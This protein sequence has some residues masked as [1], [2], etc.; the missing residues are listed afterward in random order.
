MIYRKLYLKCDTC[1][2]KYAFS[3][4]LDNAPADCY[5][6]GRYEDIGQ[7]AFNRPYEPPNQPKRIST[8]DPDVIMR[9]IMGL[10]WPEH[11]GG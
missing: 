4:Y 8:K 11:T 9:D 2:M 7:D 1:S 6:G 5:C 3:G 10:R